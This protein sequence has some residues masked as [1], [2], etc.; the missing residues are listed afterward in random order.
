MRL[1]IIS[2]MYGNLIVLE[3]VLADV[4]RHVP[5][6]VVSFDDSGKPPIA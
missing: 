6:A 1:A 5:D 4:R 3:A 2:D